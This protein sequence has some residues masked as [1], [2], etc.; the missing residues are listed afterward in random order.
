LE[1]LHKEAQLK[2]NRQRF[3]AFRAVFEHGF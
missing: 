2:G 1:K 3:R